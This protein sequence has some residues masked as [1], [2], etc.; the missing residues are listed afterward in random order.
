MFG[1]FVLLAFLVEM[2][3]YRATGDSVTKIAHALLVVAYLGVLTSFFLK[4]RW[5]RFDGHP[6]TTGLMLALAIFVPKCQDIAA[7]SVGRLIG[8]TKFTPLLSP[9]KTWEGFAGGFAGGVFAA[10]LFAQLGPVF[11][12]GWLEAV[13]FGVVVGFVGC[14]ATWPNPSS[15]ATGRRRTL[16]RRSPGSAG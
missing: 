12:H 8:R 14:S 6:D 13:G 5:L 10:L 9:K 11:R 2:Y 15:S 4:L 16:R 1:L 7:Y 3:Q